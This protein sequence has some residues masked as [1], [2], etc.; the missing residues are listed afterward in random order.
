MFTHT[1]RDT[2][3]HRH[4][5]THTHRAIIG[6]QVMYMGGSGKAIGGVRGGRLCG[7]NHAIIV[8]MY[9]IITN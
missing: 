9:D 3:T 1:H 6:E 7:E 2:Q 8:L 4:R 5:H